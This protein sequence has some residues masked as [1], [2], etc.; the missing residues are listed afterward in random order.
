MSEKIDSKELPAK[1]QTV[2]EIAEAIYS[3]EKIENKELV[4]SLAIKY[5]FEFG[6]S[7]K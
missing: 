2:I 1:S 5:A 4:I 7:D 6:D 3:N